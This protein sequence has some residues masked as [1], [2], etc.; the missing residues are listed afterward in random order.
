MHRRN[1]SYATF[2]SFDKSNREVAP[3][4]DYVQS[5]QQEY[6]QIVNNQQNQYNPQMRRQQ[7]PKFP[8]PKERIPKQPHLNQPPQRNR[9]PS[10]PQQPPH[11]M[12][13]GSPEEFTIPEPEIGVNV[14]YPPQTQRSTSQFPE[15][16]SKSAVRK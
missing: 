5:Q 7:Q 15:N 1:T 14:F 2:G 4:F 9:G 11:Q 3:N 6:Q 10:G 16:Y 12:T 13:Q 8:S